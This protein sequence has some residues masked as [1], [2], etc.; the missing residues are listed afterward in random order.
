MHADVD[1]AIGDHNC[2]DKDEPTDVGLVF[3]KGAPGKGGQGKSISGVGP[4]SKLTVDP[5]KDKKF[6]ARSFQ[7]LIQEAHDSLLDCEKL[8]KKI[9][10]DKS[11]AY[12]KTQKNELD[13]F[14][15]Q[16][17]DVVKNSEY[18]SVQPVYGKLQ[19]KFCRSTNQHWY[20]RNIITS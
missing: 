8:L 17:Q 13:Q 19:R 1:A 9:G 14:Y 10:T 16:L 20:D 11:L 7:R 2:W 18:D 15:R 6:E 5:E 3:P 12:L 4:A